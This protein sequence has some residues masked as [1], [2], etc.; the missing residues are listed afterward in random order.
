MKIKKRMPAVLL[1]ICFLLPLPATAAYSGLPEV[2]IQSR[3]A[4]LVH[5]ETDEILYKHNIHIRRP[6]ASVTKIMTALLALEHGGLDDIV[7]AEEGDFF[8]IIPGSSNAGIKAGEQMTLRDLIY[9]AML[10]SAN[11]ACNIIARHVAGSVGAFMEMMNLRMAELGCENTR[12]TNPHGLPDPDN[13]YTTAYDVY[14]MM[15]ECLNNS[16]FMEIAN[17]EYIVLPPTNLTPDG[18]ALTTTNNLITRRRF[19]DYI[20]PYARGVKTG[21]TNDAGHCLVSTAERDGITLIS[22]ILGAEADSET[23]LIRSF[24]ETRDLFVWGFENFTIKRILSRVEQLIGIPVIQGKGQDRVFLIPER[25][26][27]ALVP[28]FLNPEDIKSNSVIIVYEPEGVQAP[29]AAGTALGEIRLTYPGREAPYAVIPL[30]ASISIERDTREAIQEGI[31]DIIT[32]DWIRW[33]ILGIVGI[34]ALYILLAVALNSRRRRR[35]MRA[36]NYRGRKRY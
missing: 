35:N 25:S 23:G 17:T 34:A 24:T 30:V 28:K 20:Y 16:A 26:V 27:E 11:E 3:S 13:H 14:L 36:S 31:T 32:Q 7:T 8:D 12:F 6:P 10:P 9:C 21:R 4:I 29:V 1:L 2:D 5:A 15:R 19:P 18:R 33:A 22:V